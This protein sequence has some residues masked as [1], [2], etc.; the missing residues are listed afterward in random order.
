MGHGTRDKVSILLIQL[1]H[2]ASY[3]SPIIS[4]SNNRIIYY[5]LIFKNVQISNYCPRA[6]KE[7][8]H[9]KRE[10]HCFSFTIMTNRNAS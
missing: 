6:L 5:E 10:I 9:E 3:Q 2:K 4:N 1:V 7:N 8:C